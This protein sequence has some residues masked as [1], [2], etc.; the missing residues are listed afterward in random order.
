MAFSRSPHLPPEIILEVANN[1]SIRRD[2]ATLSALSVT[3]TSYLD[4]CRS[5][6]FQTIRISS[7]GQQLDDQLDG[8][9]DIWDRN[10]RVARY[11]KKLEFHLGS[12][13]SLHTTTFELLAQLENVASLRLFT[14]PDDHPSDK[15]LNTEQISQLQSLLSSPRITTLDLEDMVIHPRLFNHC[16]QLLHLRMFHVK[17]YATSTSNPHGREPAGNR[18]GC[19]PSL[20]SLLKFQSTEGWR[21]IHNTLLNVTALDSLAFG[22][23]AYGHPLLTVTDISSQISS[24]VCLTH[25]RHLALEATV[26]EAVYTVPRASI[27]AALPSPGALE[28]V[29]ITFCNLYSPLLSVDMANECGNLDELLSSADW[30]SLTSITIFVDFNHKRITSGGLSTEDLLQ[31]TRQRYFPRL[32]LHLN[33]SL[34]VL[35]LPRR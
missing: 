5:S 10:P 33:R 11:V 30:C 21:Y 4:V 9:T 24:L 17:T 2:L 18:F 25:L 1:L 16:P 35:H 26:I 20:C 34:E 27:L 12:I 22:V 19:K 7:L 29:T 14:R 6:I 15:L 13:T 31:E 32:L 28:S 23:K 8:L 3:S